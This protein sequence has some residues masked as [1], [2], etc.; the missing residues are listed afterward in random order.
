[1]QAKYTTLAK[2]AFLCHSTVFMIVTLIQ[3]VRNKWY[4]DIY[5]FVS[6]PIILFSHKRR[7]LYFKT[8]FREITK[9]RMCIMSNGIF[10]MGDLHR[11]FSVT[12]NYHSKIDI[13]NVLPDF[14]WGLRHWRKK[15][16]PNQDWK[17]ISDIEG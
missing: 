12:W 7:Y 2:A 17:T 13:T 3:F 4:F 10:C 15:Y 14:M 11:M 6:K 5:F 1:M 16:Y 9:I 8:L